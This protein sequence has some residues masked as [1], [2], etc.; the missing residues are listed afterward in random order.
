MFEEQQRVWADYS[1]EI[2]AHLHVIVVDDCSPK[3]QRLSRK[4]VLETGIASLRMHRLTVKKRWNW[5]ACRNLGARLASTP[6]LILTDMDH[7]VP[8]ETL[9]RLMRGDL[10]D[11]SAYRFSRVTA[12]RRWPYA[13]AQQP[14]Y[15]PHN[16]TWLLTKALFWSD[17]VGGYDERLSGCYGTS[18]EFTDRVTAAARAR[19]LL[20]EIIVRYPREIV[21]DA[22]TSPEVYTRKN[23]PANDAD[24]AQRKA[25]R[26][27]LAH[28][29]PLH[30]LIPSETIYDS[31]A[32]PA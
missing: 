7:V 30:D 22:S 27:L 20:P 1:P 5:L 29:R 21:P 4:S 23:D 11:R 18:A 32:V 15:K 6:W 13:A 25:A 10:D 2:K 31:T 12:T 16:D 24:L 17:A 26:R 14:L 28:W 9:T 3:G 8:C 19:I